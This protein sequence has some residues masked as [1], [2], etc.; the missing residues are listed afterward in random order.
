VWAEEF[1]L[2]ELELDPDVFWRLEKR[3]F[4]LKVD[5]FKRA[6]ERRESAL[7]RQALRTA[8]YKAKDRNE[9]Q[10]AANRLRRYPVKPWLKSQ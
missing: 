1:G 7:I 10:R 5:A 9:M 4:D 3:E 2:G 6:E 8:S